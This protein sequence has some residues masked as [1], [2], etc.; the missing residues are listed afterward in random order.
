[1]RH[2]RRARRD[3]PGRLRGGSPPEDARV[4]GEGRSGGGRSAGSRSGRCRSA[5]R[6]G[7]TPQVLGSAQQGRGR[8]RERQDPGH[9]LELLA[10]LAIDVDAVGSARR[11]PRGPR[12]ARASCRSGAGRHGRN[13]IRWGRQDSRGWKV[14]IFHGYLLRGTGSNVYNANVAQALA[15]LGHEVHLLCQDLDAGSLRSTRSAAGRGARRRGSAPTGSITLLPDI[16][17][18]LPVYVRR[19]LR[20][21]RGQALRG[22]QPTTSSSPTSRRTSR[23]SATSVDAPA[24]STPRWPTIWSWAR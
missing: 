2:A 20:G 9:G 13:L 3:G 12:P 16:G 19:L 18:L 24:A 23:R 10:G 8:R 6:S 5:A 11:R 21:L 1:M 17:G 14:L 22:A 4:L 15:R 7:G